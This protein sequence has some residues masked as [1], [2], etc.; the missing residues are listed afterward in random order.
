MEDPNELGNPADVQH[1]GCRHRCHFQGCLWQGKKSRG[2]AGSRWSSWLKARNASSSRSY[3]AEA[4]WTTLLVGLA[5]TSGS[6]RDE[7]RNMLSLIKMRTNLCILAFFVNSV[8]C[9]CRIGWFMREIFRQND[10]RCQDCLVTDCHGGP[11]DELRGG[12][13]NFYQFPGSE[14]SKWAHFW[15]NTSQTLPLLKIL[16]SVIPRKLQ[17]FF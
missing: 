2:I 17:L 7:I 16:N 3:A 10:Q 14:G 12:A 15:V 1:Q 9:I 4:L 6:C 5:G 8:Q 11:E 13:M